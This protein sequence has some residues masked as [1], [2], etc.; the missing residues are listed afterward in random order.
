MQ[1]SAKGPVGRNDA[2][3][4]ISTHLRVGHRDVWKR[5]RESGDQ[6]SSTSYRSHAFPKLVIKYEDDDDV[7]PIHNLK[8]TLHQHI[9]HNI[10]L[11]SILSQTPHRDPMT[12]ITNQIRHQDVCRIRFE[13]NA[14]VIVL[15]VA[16]DDVDE[17]G[18][19]DVPTVGCGKRMVLEWSAEEEEDG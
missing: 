5:K 4:Q 19:V 12:S 11:S 14:I 16:V 2:K 18:S 10:H 6:P 17:G 9:L 1:G 3:I 8:L 7:E 15:N 13:G